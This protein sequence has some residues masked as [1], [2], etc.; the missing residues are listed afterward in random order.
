NK[1][2]SREDLEAETEKYALACARNRPVDTV[3]MQRVFVEIY[4]QH[5][6]EYMGSLLGAF[7]ESMGIG[8]TADRAEDLDMMESIDNGL[9]AAVNDNDDKFPPDFRLSK[10]NRKKTK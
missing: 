5:Q 4:K 2:V 3:Y 7:F 1:V 10:K 9:A 6:G 8:V